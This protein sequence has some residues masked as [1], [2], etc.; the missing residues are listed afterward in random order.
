[1]A[2]RVPPGT[3]KMPLAATVAESQ[4]RP[5]IVTLHVFA[6]LLRENGRIRQLTLEQEVGSM[7]GAFGYSLQQLLARRAKDSY[8]I[9]SRH[10][11]DM[12][13]VYFADDLESFRHRGQVILRVFFLINIF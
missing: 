13:I 2:A 11:L 8:R 6:W 3:A 12:R 1:K 10:K 9:A 7:L 4:P 5:A